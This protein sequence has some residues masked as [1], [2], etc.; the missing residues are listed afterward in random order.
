MKQA[1]TTCYSLEKRMKHPVTIIISKYINKG[2]QH[3]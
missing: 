2:M 1:E 3:E